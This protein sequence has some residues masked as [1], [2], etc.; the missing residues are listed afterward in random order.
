MSKFIYNEET[1]QH[2]LNGKIIPSVSQVIDTLNDFSGI[3]PEVL[4]RK[5]ELGIEFHKA[6]R[7]HLLDDLWFDSIDPDLVKPMNTFIDWWDKRK[8]SYD[9][10]HIESPMYHKTLK[11]CGCPDL[12]CETDLFDWKLRKYM[13]VVDVLKLEAY[14]HM[15]GVERREKWTVCFD[16]D[17]KVNMYEARNRKAWGIY[18]K[19][20]EKYY[21]DMEFNELMSRWRGI[22]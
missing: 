8:K 1:R 16:L 15:L 12:V 21:S 13:P 2:T 3:D 4:E 22:N 19:L 9:I 17:G 18:R 6:I 14:K 5:A 20:L 7:L 11:Y 10:T